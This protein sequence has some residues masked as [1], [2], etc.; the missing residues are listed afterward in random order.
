MR[1]KDDKLKT[2]RKKRWKKAE[3]IKMGKK[4][5]AKGTKRGKGKGKKKDTQR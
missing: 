2:K 1:E 4:E 3:E 5:R